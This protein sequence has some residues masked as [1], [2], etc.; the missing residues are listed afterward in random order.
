MKNILVIGFS[1]RNIVCS[2]KRAGYNMFAIDAFCDSDM[3]ECVEAAIKLDV[4][5]GFDARNIEPSRLSEMIENFGI[6]FDAIIPASGFETMKFPERFPILQNE[7][8]IMREVSDKSRFAKILASLDMP[9]PQTYPLAELE[10]INYPAMVKPACSGGGIL[11]RVVSSPEELHIYLK[12]LS[13]LQVPFRKENMILQDYL[14]GTPA[15]VSVISTES[16]ARTIAINEQ[17]IGIPWLTKLPF[18]YC[19]NITPFI[20]PYANQMKNIAEELIIELGLIGSTGVDFLITKDGPVIIEV[21]ARFQGSLDTVEM[22]T[23]SNIFGAHMQAFDGSIR[24]EVTGSKQYAVRAIL[25]GD[26]DKEITDNIHNTILE[27][28][29]ADVPNVGDMIHVDEPLTS[30]LSTGHS[31]GAA[32]NKAKRSVMFI[33]ECLDLGTSHEGNPTTNSTYVHNI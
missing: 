3:L 24:P 21:N 4:G 11:N 29:I 10:D 26:R 17:L 28:Q 19:G 31:R 23:G 2:G 27:K 13:K 33:R 18:A 15:S 20:T 25:Y 12:C 16:E 1:T 14:L 32:I 7:Y 5:E 30:V 22:A 8:N 6:D 9:H